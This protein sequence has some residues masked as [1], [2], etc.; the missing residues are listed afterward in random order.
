[1]ARP[2]TGAPAPAL[3]AGSR[4]RSFAARLLVVLGVNLVV[5]LVVAALAALEEGLPPLRAETLAV[6]LL[7]VSAAMGLMLA[8]RRLD[9]SLP[10]L[11]VVAALL[12]ANRWALTDDPSARLAMIAAIAGAIALA[13]AFVTWYGRIS[14]ALWTALLATA[15]LAYAPLVKPLPLTAQA[16]WEWPAAVGV[17]VGLV[18]LGAAILGL[19][20]MVVP[21]SQP[22]ILRAG[23]QGVIGLAA[24]WTLA[25]LGVAVGAASTDAADAAGDFAGY[26]PP[27]AAAAM[28]G[29]YI[30]RGRWGALAA[31]GA[32]CL[33]HL[34]WA[35]ASS[36]DLGRPALDRAVPALAPV[37]AVP[38]YLVLDAWLRRRT[39]ESAPTGL[40]A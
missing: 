26:L 31:V 30:L 32:A 4:D 16:G 36:A 3:G 1:M 2:P 18:A 10:A 15:Y 27:L 29:A 24:A 35:Y 5:L 39:H 13:S 40:L 23:P 33:A 14:A 11:F 19:A 6:G 7:P 20:G 34:V 37:V 28:S 25:A 21:P 22:P 38:V 12:R 17:S 9:L 8:C